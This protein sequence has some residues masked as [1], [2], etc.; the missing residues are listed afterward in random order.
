MKKTGAIFLVFCMLTISVLNQFMK[1]ER[2]AILYIATGKYFVFWPKFY[3][4][5]EKNFLPNNPKDYYVF[6]DNVFENKPANVTRV[7]RKWHGFPE[8]TLDR[9]EMFLTI[10]DKLQKYDYIY[11]LNANAEVVN[12]VGEEIFPTKEQGIMVATHPRHYR[13]K[14]RAEYPYEDNPQSTAYIASNEGEW[15]VQGGFNGGRT[16][17]FLRMA[18]VLDE[19][20]RQDKKNNVLARFHDESHLNR[21]IIHKNPLVM[22]PNYIWQNLDSVLYEKYIQNNEMKIIIRSKNSPEYGGTEYFR[23][24]PKMTLDEQFAE[25]KFYL[26]AKTWKDYLQLA[27]EEKSRYCRRQVS[28]CAKVEFDGDKMI[29]QWDRWGTETFVKDTAHHRFVVIK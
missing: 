14:N 18:R 2:I 8:D 1:P 25:K 23:E 26:Q 5:M 13:L 9:Y 17:D 21:Y 27:N 29:V 16:K 6:T 10:E 22:P 15:Y 20:I 28:D 3:E 4:S 19:N 24:I 7:Y 12:P 11:F